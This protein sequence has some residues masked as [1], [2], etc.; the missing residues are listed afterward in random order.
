MF[1]YFLYV[2][3]CFINNKYIVF[4]NRC[5]I[6]N[7]LKMKNNNNKKIYMG[8]GRVFY[9]NFEILIDS[10]FWKFNKFYLVF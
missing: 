4:V 3:K 8:F 9:I 6:V 7:I 5:L 2:G 10:I 1:F